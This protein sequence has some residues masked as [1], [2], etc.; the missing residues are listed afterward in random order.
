MW[1]GKEGG[2]HESPSAYECLKKTHT[3]THKCGLREAGKVRKRTGRAARHGRPS[4]Y[5]FKRNHTPTK[6]RSEGGNQGREKG[7]P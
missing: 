2:K 4:V 6:K 7:G 1:Q 5:L 3:P